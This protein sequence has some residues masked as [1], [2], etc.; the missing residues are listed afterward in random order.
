MNADNEL[1][2]VGDASAAISIYRFSPSGELA[3]PP[4]K[5]FFPRDARA[6]K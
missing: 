2:A 4:I 6:N 5:H 1:L 3:H